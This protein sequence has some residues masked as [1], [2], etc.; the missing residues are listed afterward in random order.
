MGQGRVATAAPPRVSPDDGG[1]AP[2]TRSRPTLL[3]RL[4]PRVGT[5][6][7][8]AESGGADVG[9]DLRRHQA[10]VAQQLLH[11]A[12]VGA[13]VQQVRGEAVAQRVRSGSR[14]QPRLAEVLFQ[15]PGDAPRG[16]AGG[17]SG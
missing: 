8:G 7:G 17:Q 1:A 15:H 9:V 3:L 4:S 13:A 2:A 10:L 12:D 16:Q 14:V 6:V 11:A 5:L